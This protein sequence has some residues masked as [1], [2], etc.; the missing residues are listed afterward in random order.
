MPLVAGSLDL[1][2]CENSFS[3]LD[4]LWCS[5]VLEL[6]VPWWMYVDEYIKFIYHQSLHRNSF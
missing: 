3:E 5:T 6:H 2:T 4:N 1:L